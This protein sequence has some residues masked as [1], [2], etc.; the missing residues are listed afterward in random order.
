MGV[1]AQIRRELLESGL[2]DWIGLWELVRTVREYEQLDKDA[3]ENLP[4]SLDL[5]DELLNDGVMDI[6]NLAHKRVTPWGV[7]VEEALKRVRQG[8]ATL[9]RDPNFGEVCWLAN[10]PKGDAEATA[11]QA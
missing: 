7:T 11:A 4:R 2:L 10:T 8:W 3:P 5:I 9:G 1:R 6:G